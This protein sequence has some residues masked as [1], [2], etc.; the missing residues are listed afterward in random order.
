MYVFI[1]YFVLTLPRRFILVP[2]LQAE[3]QILAYRG[4][5]E[6]SFTFKDSICI[7]KIIIHILCIVHT[8]FVFIIPHKLV[9]Q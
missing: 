6:F 8:F 4:K 1:A 5:L 2:V 9:V 7:N 3:L